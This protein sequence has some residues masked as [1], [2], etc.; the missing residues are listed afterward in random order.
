MK[1]IIDDIRLIFKCC[2]L[3]YEDGLSQQEISDMLQVSRP[4]VARMIKNGREQGIVKIKVINPDSLIFG[5]LE[6]EIEKNFGL[7]EVIIVPSGNADPVYE[8]NENLAN[9]TFKFLSRVLENKDYVG[10]TMGRTLKNLLKG[11]HDVEFRKCTFVPI[12]GGV[13]EN[14]YDIHS[15]YLATSFAEIYHADC[16]QFFAPLVFSNK[17]MLHNFL[18]EYSMQKIM[19]AFKKISIAIMGI[20]MPAKQKSTLVKAGYIKEKLFDE[21]IAKGMVGD[22]AAQFYDKD[23]NTEQFESFNNLI[24]AMSIE[25]LKKVPCRIGIVAGKDKINSLIGAIRGNLINV[26]ITDSDCAKELFNH[27]ENNLL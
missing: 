19:R 22:V 10:I 1:K 24:A 9:E 17:D 18:C 26:L 7:E 13:A 4:S 12:V 21:F 23:G 27:R 6:R 3:Y 8:P 15:N 16:L 2:G 25:N 20:G 11:H 5:N 14:S